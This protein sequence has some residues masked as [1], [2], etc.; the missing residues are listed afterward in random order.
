MYVA[1]YFP[2][3]LKTSQRIKVGSFLLGV[4]RGMLIDFFVKFNQTGAFSSLLNCDTSEMFSGNAILQAFNLD[5]SDL[6]YNKMNRLLPAFSRP[7]SGA[8]TSP[9]FADHQPSLVPQNSTST[10]I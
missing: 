8:E 10:R 9:S 2:L 4:G 3:I 5:S 7:R 1:F 6:M